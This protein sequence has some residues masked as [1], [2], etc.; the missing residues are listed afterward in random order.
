[1]DNITEESS[2]EEQKES[3][4]LS[5]GAIFISYSI[6]LCNYSSSGGSCRPKRIL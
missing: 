1:M 6:I 5:P 3:T 2:K 4:C